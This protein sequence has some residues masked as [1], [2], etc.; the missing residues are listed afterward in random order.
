MRGWHQTVLA[1][2]SCVLSG[3]YRLVVRADLNGGSAPACDL[4]NVL[5]VRPSL[6]LCFL[7]AAPRRS[8]NFWNIHALSVT[9]EWRT[10]TVFCVLRNYG[11]DASVVKLTKNQ[12]PTLSAESPE[13]TCQPKK[14]P[15]VR[16]AT[17]QW[18]LRQLLRLSVAVPKRT[19]G[20]QHEKLLSACK[21][22]VLS[23]AVL[24]PTTT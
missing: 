24:V 15:A 7:L 20:T 13:E 19:P 5:G 16:V 8:C 4:H 3:V 14:E 9:C 22:Y 1:R 17:Q 2:F 6:S 12:K 23:K 18:T 11:H 21:P 10:D